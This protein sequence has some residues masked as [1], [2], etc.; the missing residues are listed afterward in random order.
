MKL[1]V[2]TIIELDYT[3]KEASKGETIDTTVEEVAVKE[4]IFNKEKKYAPVLVIVGEKELPEPVE[5]ALEEMGKGD[6][7]TIKL[8]PEHAFGNR[9]QALVAVV[10]LK[11]FRQRKINPVPGLMVDL[12]GRLGKVQSVSGGR[13]RV[14]FNH[15]L[16]GKEIEYKIK[17]KKVLEKA[18]EQLEALFEKYF[19]GMPEKDRIITEKSG[20]V[21]IKLKGIHN[22]Q[23]KR[24]FAEKATNH[25]KGIEKVRF[26]E[27]FEK[28]EKKSVQ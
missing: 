10:P 5:K 16:A 17:V 21:E 15:P 18:E 27:E 14:D 28:Q 9:N 26:I 25:I 20:I 3:A 23:S 2:G 24:L 7:K 19:P 13:V 22:P 8:A 12:N 1:K 4:G 11:E 6:E